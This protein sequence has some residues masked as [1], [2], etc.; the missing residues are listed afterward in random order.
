MMPPTYGVSKDK[1][2]R[3]KLKN[4]SIAN[5]VEGMARI[6]GE[7]EKKLLEIYKPPAC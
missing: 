7:T 6:E 5:H 2:L 3:H 1:L 4:S